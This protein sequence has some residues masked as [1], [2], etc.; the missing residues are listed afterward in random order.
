MW[1][2]LPPTGLTWWFDFN[3]ICIYESMAC[4]LLIKK[5]PLSSHC[6]FKQMSTNYSTW[7]KKNILQSTQW[8]LICNQLKVSD[9]SLVFSCLLLCSLCLSPSPSTRVLV[10]VS[11]HPSISLLLSRHHRCLSL[12]ILQN[13][14]GLLGEQDAKAFLQHHSVPGELVV[15]GEAR[16]VR[17]A[18]GLALRTELLLVAETET[19]RR[20]KAQFTFRLGINKY[21]IFIPYTIL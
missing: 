9:L 14:S 19:K 7:I 5:T 18:G 11:I 17:R 12:F 20:D 4:F 16:W 3:K 1:K 13:W 8:Q 21:N 10:L 2:L 15:W 6:S